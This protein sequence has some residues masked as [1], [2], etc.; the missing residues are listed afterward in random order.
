MKVNMQVKKNKNFLLAYTSE[1]SLCYQVARSSKNNAT[2]KRR[3]AMNTA[4]TLNENEV[5]EIPD[6]GDRLIPKYV[7]EV[8]VADIVDQGVSTLRNNRHLGRGIPYVKIGR[9]IRYDLNDVYE[10]MKK[11]KIFPKEPL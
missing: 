1:H 8:V 3:E 10:Y 6:D 5:A 4:K 2:V 7:S 11:R 9:S